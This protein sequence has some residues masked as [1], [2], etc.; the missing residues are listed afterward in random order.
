VLSSG[1][2]EV[3]TR[4]AAMFPT[5]FLKGYVYWK[6]RTDPA[7]RAVS[8]SLNGARDLPL[9]DLG[10]GTGLLAFYLREHGFSGRVHGVDIDGPKIQVAQSIAEKGGVDALFECRDFRDM[11][12]SPMGHV[13]MLDVLLY[14]TPD[15]QRELIAR[16]VEFVCPKKG[17]FIIRSGIGDGSWRHRFTHTLD[18]IARMIGWMMKVPVNYPSREI[19]TEVFDR[20]GFEVEFRPLWG[21]TPYNNHLVVARRRIG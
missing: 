17:V 2:K 20:C 8:D 15:V 4:I 5:R 3:A 19:F 16:A 10:C 9:L 7:Y 12:D 1:N 11:H 14:V 18:N 13:T 21:R 6:I